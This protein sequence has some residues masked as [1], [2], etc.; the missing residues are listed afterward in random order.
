MLLF[1]ST[2]VFAQGPGQLDDGLPVESQSP[3]KETADGIERDGYRIQQSIELGYRVT[4]TTGS[5]PMYD[6]LVNLQTGP[7]I[8]DQSLSM[9]SLTHEGLFDSLTASSFGWGGDPSNAARLRAV[10]YRIFN[11]TA[12]FRRYQ[13][14][15]NY[16]LFANPLNPPHWHPRRECRQLA[17][18]V[19]QPTSDV[20]LRTN[21]VSAT[22]VQPIA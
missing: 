20:R 2:C 21:A 10:K 19:L 16:N 11:F 5:V 18:R 17:P 3:T 1:M 22:P 15:F 14:Y 8:L 12:S 7:R 6:T 4:D 13:N 9:Q